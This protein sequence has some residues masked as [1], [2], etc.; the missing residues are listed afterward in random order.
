M[1]KTILV[2]GATG[3]QG[4]AVIDALVSQPDQSY[5]I[6]AVTRDANSSSAQKLLKKSSSVKLVEGNLDDVPALFSA[7]S[8]ISSPIWGVYSVQVSQGKGVTQEGEIRQGKAVIDEALKNG[9]EM[10]VYSSVERG[11]DEKSWDN[12]TP[13][14]HFQSK[15]HLERYLREKAEGTEMSWTVLRPVAFMDVSLNSFIPVCWQ[16]S[17]GNEDC[18]TR[19]IS[20]IRDRIGSLGCQDVSSSLH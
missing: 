4:G 8:K 5:T 3:K 13:I 14:P 11:G 16:S 7:A 9:V 2:T 17:H 19:D 10:F 18:E 15:Y 12:E 20:N 1:S 6:L